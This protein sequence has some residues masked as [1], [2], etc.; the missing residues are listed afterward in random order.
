MVKQINQME[1]NELA[2]PEYYINREL[3]LL[4]FNVRV[5]AQARNETTPLLERLNYLCISCSNL[6]EFFEVRVASVLQMANMDQG[7]IS[8]DGLTSHEQLE[9]ISQ[10]A[11]NLVDEHANEWKES[12][13]GC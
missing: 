9:K 8:S 4:E 11:H 12:H 3:S 1:N 10:K 6:D 7:A 2:N 13:P 5:L